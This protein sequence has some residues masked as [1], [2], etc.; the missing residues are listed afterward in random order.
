[1]NVC[2]VNWATFKFAPKNVFKDFKLFSLK[3]DVLAKKKF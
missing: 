2:G 1:M 3:L